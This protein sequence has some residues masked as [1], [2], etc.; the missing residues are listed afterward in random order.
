M[1]IRLIKKLT[2]EM[3]DLMASAVTDSEDGLST[4]DDPKYFT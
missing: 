1:S 2:M 3:M 4:S